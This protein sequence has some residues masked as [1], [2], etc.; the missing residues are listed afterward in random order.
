MKPCH[1]EGKSVLKVTPDKGAGGLKIQASHFTSFKTPPKE[2][3]EAVD[4]CEKDD[5]SDKFSMSKLCQAFIERC[6]VSE[7]H[8]FESKSL[9]EEFGVKQRRIYDLMNIMEGC[10][11]L[12]KHSKGKYQWVGIEKS[13]FIRPESQKG[14]STSLR[15]IA[16]RIKMVMS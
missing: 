3:V 2:E 15:Q 4:S 10:G 16:A 13:E 9:V 6:N 12:K 14:D 1:S 8:I 11:C 5:S 7:N